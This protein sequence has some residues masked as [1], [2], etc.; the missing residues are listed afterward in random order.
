MHRRRPA[1]DGVVENRADELSAKNA[2]TVDIR[3]IADRDGIGFRR[4]VA[5]HQMPAPVVFWFIGSK[6][7][8]QQIAPALPIQ[9]EGRGYTGMD[10]DPAFVDMQERQFR[11]PVETGGRHA[12]AE[13]HFGFKA[14]IVEPPVALAAPVVGPAHHVLVV[15]HQAYPPE[16]GGGADHQ[17]VEHR[18][19][20]R[21][22]IDVVTEKDHRPRRGIGPDPGEQPVQRIDTAVDV[23]DSERIGHSDTAL[24]GRNRPL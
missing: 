22:A 7:Q 23:A 2:G 16:T 14:A 13:R 3:A 11:R 4:R 8:P 17:P 9:R 24:Q 10:V 21:P 15:A 19:A 5:V 6:P 1:G 18:A 20:V 12:A